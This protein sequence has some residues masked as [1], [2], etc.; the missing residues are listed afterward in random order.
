MA[1]LCN[2]CGISY[3]RA[4]AKTSNGYLNLDQL[5]QQTGPGRR[6][7]Q[8]ALKRHWKPIPCQDQHS[9]SLYSTSSTYP[10]PGNGG[11]S[12]N[13]QERS[14]GRSSFPHGGPKFTA[15]NRARKQNFRGRSRPC[16]PRTSKISVNA[17]LV[18]EE[19]TDTTGRFTIR[20]ENSKPAPCKVI[21]NKN[22]TLGDNIPINRPENRRIDVAS[23][24]HSTSDQYPY[25]RCHQSSSATTGEEE[26][27]LSKPPLPRTPRP[28]AR[29]PRNGDVHLRDVSLRQ[30][31]ATCS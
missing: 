18:Q 22:T 12:C 13:I 1:T 11:R 21:R 9:S 5:A 14:S 28:E 17:L 2:A 7:I 10:F 3:R 23:L 24:V 6:S 16:S 27:P 20:L 19:V 4:L 31:L 26:N 30:V 8:K 15:L 25:D 29:L